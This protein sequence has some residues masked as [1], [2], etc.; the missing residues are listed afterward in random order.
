M[1]RLAPPP[2]A[3]P[4]IALLLALLPAA[5]L[6]DSNCDELRSRIDAK[7][8]ASGASG[9]A[10]AVVDKDAKVNGKVV[11]SCDLG[12]RQIVYSPSAAS[13]P[14]GEEAMLT[15]CKDGT[16]KRGGDCPR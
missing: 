15:E 5:V 3:I 1:K 9:Y 12:R 7:I 4:S 6:A 13:A 2:I 11:G 14:R 10:L 16:V 8:R